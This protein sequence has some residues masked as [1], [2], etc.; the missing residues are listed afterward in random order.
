MTRKKK[1]VLYIIIAI[2]L[3]PVM[4]ALTV[5]ALRLAVK[6]SGHQN[7]APLESSADIS[8]DALLS[9]GTHASKDG[10]TDKAKQLLKQARQIYER[11]NNVEGIA[12]TDMQLY[13]IEHPIQTPAA[14]TEPTLAETK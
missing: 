4:S 8:A 10:D 7:Q 9:Q 2:V 13:L 12:N 6:D 1:L 14:Q 5:F 11:E 3:V